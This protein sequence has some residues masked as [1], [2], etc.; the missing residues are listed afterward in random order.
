MA[1][2]PHF[3]PYWEITGVNDS[4]KFFSALE[5]L[6]VLPVYFCVEG[7]SIAPDVQALFA[8]HAT[9]PGL[10]IPT[11]TGWPKPKTFHVLATEEFLDELAATAR[12]HAEPEICD[13]LHA[14]KDRRV[15]L[16]WYDAFDLPLI[17]DESVPEKS[18]QEFCR[19][20]GARYSR[21]GPTNK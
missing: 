1:D 9:E 18:V 19:R 6:L 14:Y 21:C 13:H 10:A 2:T 12:N 5:E 20:L 16:Q 11:G 8:S 3:V 7:T 15:L 4:E 17:V